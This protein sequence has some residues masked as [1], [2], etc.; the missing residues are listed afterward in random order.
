MS[1]NIGEDSKRA[2]SRHRENRK[3]NNNNNILGY[4]MEDLYV[5]TCLEINGHS[6]GGREKLVS[7]LVS[8]ASPKSRRYKDELTLTVVFFL[9]NVIITKTLGR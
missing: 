4:L 5:A 6:A 9:L 2:A 7:T 1:R 8:I 3:R